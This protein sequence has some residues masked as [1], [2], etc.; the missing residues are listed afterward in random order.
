MTGED[1]NGTKDEDGNPQEKKRRNSVNLTELAYERIEHLIITCELKPG[2]FL[3]IQD[4][5]RETGLSR[6]PV[7]QAVSRLA[8]DTLVII[9]PRHGLQIAPIDLARERMLLRLRRDLE[10]FVVSLAAEHSTS[11]HRSQMLHI[12]RILKD[13]RDTMAI[14]DFNIFDRRIDRLI[15]LA[16]GEPF[17]EHTL[18]PLHTLFRRIGLIH[19]RNI[20]G[21]ESL[22]GSIQSHIGILEAIA[23]RNVALAV[24]A[25]D[26]LIDYVDRMFDALERDIDPSIL[27]SSLESLISL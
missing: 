22:A 6:T 25:S 14:G 12:T 24:E 11:T 13:Q 18:R 1:K 16:A 27:D 9:Q 2:R 4:L 19:H 7:H 26:Q 17:L 20:G 5:Q 21:A 3:S 8:A 23:K 10:R 15:L